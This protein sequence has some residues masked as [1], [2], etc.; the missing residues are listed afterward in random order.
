MRAAL[1]RAMW[2]DRINA[3]TRAHCADGRVGLHGDTR[4]DPVS[5]AL[6]AGDPA[7]ERDQPAG[8]GVATQK[9]TA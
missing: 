7:D 4:I 5:Q 6:D 2:R 8:D 1:L 3:R 9:G